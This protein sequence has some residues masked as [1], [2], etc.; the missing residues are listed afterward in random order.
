VSSFY[1]RWK[2]CWVGLGVAVLSLGGQWGG[3]S[4]IAAERILFNYSI[5]GRSISVRALETYTRDGILTEDLVSYARF[6]KPSQLAQLR[7]GLQ[8]KVELSPVAISQFL[9]SPPGEL[10]LE[11]VSRLVQT[12]SGQGSFYA[13]RSTL[14]LAATDPEGLTPLSILRHYPNP[15]IVV[16]V[17]EIV[18]LVDA[19]NRFLKQTDA[20]TQEI[21]TLSKTSPL[22]AAQAK[23]LGQFKQPGPFTWTKI[24]L[25]LQDSTEKRLRYTGKVR[26][27]MAD[28][29]LPAT[30][31]P[32]PLVI[33]SHGLNS[34][35]ESYAYLAQHLASYGFAVAVPEHPGS[36]KQQLQ[37]LLEGRGREVAEPFEF[38]DR[39][40]DIQF[41]LNSL[42]S[43]EKTDVQFQG[44]LDFDRVGIIGQSFGGY[45]SLATAGAPLSFS[46]LAQNCGRELNTTLN[47]SLGLQCQA[48]RL[49][50]AQ[51]ELGD[52]RIKA[53]IAI[54]P[55]TSGVFGPESLGQIKVPV[56]MVAGGRDIVA[57]ALPEQIQ[58]FAQLKTLQQYLVLI[59][60][61]NHFSTIAP[62]SHETEALSQIKGLEGP[63]PALARSYINVLSVLF[64]QSYLRGQQGD[65][66]F[67]SPAG[68]ESLSQ[69]PLPLSIVNAL[70]A[71]D[72]LPSNVKPKDLKK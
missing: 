25:P 60:N 12:G 7:E 47:I 10:L 45:T 53:A 19:A 55:I 3:G 48:L 15:N 18:G 11:R 46:N 5:L 1:R 22:S 40:L 64:M 6:V 34:D 59:D 23:Q 49:Q 38:L 14:V 2:G 39:P 42:Q 51:Y 26:T 32:Q 63:S 24:T 43:L 8:Q 36:N 70:P 68:A 37:G 16:N 13:L 9:Y 20:I 71:K 72:L 33:I 66:V 62:S 31:Q 52:S 44:K 67:L 50:P 56:M 28:I 17:E 29:Y 65:R 58:P 69:S 27:F 21:Q 41:L 35:R 61:S 57:P 54:N 30:N 4:A